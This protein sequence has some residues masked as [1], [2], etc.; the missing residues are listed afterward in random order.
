MILGCVKCEEGFTKV[1]IKFDDHFFFNQPNYFLWKCSTFVGRGT[2][3]SGL[4][5]FIFILDLILVE[6]LECVK[7]EYNRTILSYFIRDKIIENVSYFIRDKR[8]PIYSIF[9]QNFAMIEILGCVMVENN[10][11][12][13]LEFVSVVGIQNVCWGSRRRSGLIHT[14]FILD[15]G[16]VRNIRTYKMLKTMGLYFHIL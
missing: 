15:L 14:I 4:K 5:N 10:P 13:D 1:Y 3:Q 16:V 9:P 2:R 7:F 6:I 12:F 11:M 8:N